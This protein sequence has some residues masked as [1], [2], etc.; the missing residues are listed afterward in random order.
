MSR[1]VLPSLL[2]VAVACGC[3]IKVP[4]TQPGRRFELVSAATAMKA[5]GSLDW[6]RYEA[7]FFGRYEAG[8]VVLLLS[9]DDSGTCS[10][11]TGRVGASEYGHGDCSVLIGLERCPGSYELGVIG[12]HGAYRRV[13]PRRVEDGAA[14]EALGQAIAKGRVVETASGR[15]RDAL[16]GLSLNAE[17]VDA[18]S[19]PD[20][21]DGPTL[22]RLGVEGDGIG[23]PW[24]A[25][26][27]GEAGTIVGPFSM[28]PPSAFILD[29]RVYLSFTVA[30][31]TGCGGVGTE[32]HAVEAGKLRRVL[33]SFANAN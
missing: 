8:T 32:V 18:L 27:R 2:A 31:C 5:D 10:V 30:I 28:R 6:Y 26:S 16:G 17:I 29:G 19:W 13:A 21:G 1:V 14:R 11:V 23:G 15:W 7:C 9:E 20:L 4:P 12:S 3:S 24:V 22:V 25:V 33:E